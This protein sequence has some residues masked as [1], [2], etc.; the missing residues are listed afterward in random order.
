MYCFPYG[1]FILLLLACI[2]IYYIVPM[3]YMTIVYLAGFALVIYY[4]AEFFMPC[5]NY[6]GMKYGDF[7]PIK[8]GPFNMG[9]KVESSTN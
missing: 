5:D 2:I 8:Q 3:P 9:K 1:V 4:V 6:G 7:G